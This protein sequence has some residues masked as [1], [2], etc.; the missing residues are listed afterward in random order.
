M[1]WQSGVYVKVDQ[2]RRKQL[3]SGQARG[4]VRCGAKRRKIVRLRHGATV[5]LFADTIPLFALTCEPTTNRDVIM[6]SA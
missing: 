2:G 5:H 1:P 6:T 3:Q 4:G